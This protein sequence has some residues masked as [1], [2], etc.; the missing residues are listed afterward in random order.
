MAL[1][2]LLPAKK[3][4]IIINKIFKKTNIFIFCNLYIIMM[5]RP[6]SDLIRNLLLVEG[7]NKKNWLCKNASH[8]KLSLTNLFWS[9]SWWKKYTNH[10]ARV[11]KTS[12]FWAKPLS[13]AEATS[14]CSSSNLLLKS[15]QILF[16]SRQPLTNASIRS[17]HSSFFLSSYTKFKKMTSAQP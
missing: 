17:A 13:L 14:F 4:W 6:I 2:L 16:R 11:R 1:Y 9:V 5:L 15:L 12:S 7:V 3:W 10:W 8:L